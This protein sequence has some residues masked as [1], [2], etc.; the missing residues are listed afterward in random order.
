MKSISLS[1]CIIPPLDH[2]CKSAILPKPFPP[3]LHT[4][5]NSLAQ[6]LQY[7]QK[8]RPRF[9]TPDGSLYFLYFFS[10]R[11]AATHC[12]AQHELFFA[13]DPLFDD[14]K[15]VARGFLAA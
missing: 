8:S 5:A 10:D 6:S 13:I 12:K 7:T 15:Q 2:F 1:V 4:S 11:F 14:L 9:D 3:V